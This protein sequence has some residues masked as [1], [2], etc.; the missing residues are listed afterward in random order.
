MQEY[1]AIAHKE[2]FEQITEVCQGI[3]RIILISSTQQNDS[4]DI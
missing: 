2:N 3:F 4:W 1:F